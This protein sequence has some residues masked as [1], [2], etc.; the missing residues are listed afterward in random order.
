MC[1]FLGCCI[2]GNSLFT[3]R[4]K[5]MCDGVYNVHV[6][7]LCLACACVCVVD[8]SCDQSVK[9]V[10]PALCLMHSSS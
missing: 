9:A 4:P 5:N 7:V 6:L 8:D 1:E 2:T 3:I 10:S